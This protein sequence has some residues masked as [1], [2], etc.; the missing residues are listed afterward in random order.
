MS[1]ESII[2]LDPTEFKESEEAYQAFLS[3]A[4]ALEASEVIPFRADEL[5]ALYNVKTAQK[6]ILDRKNELEAKKI[7]E[8]ELTKMA[9]THSVA[10]AMVFAVDQAETIAA[11]PTKDIRQKRARAGLLRRV[12]LLFAEGCALLGMVP[13]DEVETIQEG[14][15]PTDSARD[16]IALSAF[17]RRH[18]K[19]LL[20]QT[21][22]TPAL[23]DEMAALGTELLATIIPTG[24]K[25]ETITPDALRQAQDLRD[26]FW[27]LLEHRYDLLVSAATKLVGRNKVRSL[28]PPLQS[29]VGTPKKT[30]TTTS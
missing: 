17:Y 21:P 12:H 15:G 3:E 9:Q 4:Q 11:R 1:E 25:V 16:C 26:R 14:N 20:N 29:R 22:S 7:S 30:E 10:L 5:I 13:L 2:E 24:A 8:E 18:H 6:N 28:V 19:V 23:Q 27:T